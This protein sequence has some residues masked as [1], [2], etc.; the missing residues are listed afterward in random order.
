MTYPNRRD[1]LGGITAAGTVSAIA[2]A[3]QPGHGDASPLQEGSLDRRLWIDV[4]TRL[5]F[6]VLEHLARGLF[7][8]NF[9]AQGE[10]AQFAA[11]EA[12]GRLMC[13]IAPWIELGGDDSE[14]GSQRTH[15]A[16]LAR[17]ALAMAVDSNSPDHMNFTEGAQPLVA[18]RPR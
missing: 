9:P 12:F 5:A 10:R 3:G 15:A 1:F 16:L 18:Q 8:R 14:E 2:G 11:L 13:G 7:S 4:A 17:T 6:P